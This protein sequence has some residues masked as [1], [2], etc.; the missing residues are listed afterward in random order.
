MNSGFPFEV[1]VQKEDFKFAA[2]HFVAYE[3]YRERIHGHNYKVGVRLLGEKIQQDGYLLDFGDVKK[4][5][6]A[7]CKS[8]NEHFI[9]PMN[10]NVLQ[11]QKFH[12]PPEENSDEEPNHLRLICEDGSMFTFP[13]SDCLL[14]P[15]VHA[16]TEEM[17][18]YIFCQIL[19]A[20]KKN[21]VNL[22]DRGIH[23]L[24]ITVQEA[25]GQESVF[26]CGVGETNVL[27]RFLPKGGVVRTCDDFKID[28][29]P[30]CRKK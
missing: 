7:L 3:G 1:H 9:C 15:I 8:W 4:A 22:Q 24:E 17:S 13:T 14:L 10:S 2:S 19:E 27:E 28:F 23:V 25:V 26:R 30:C 29:C 16:T 6:R 11:I 18:V 21:N 20:L 12:Y 5:V